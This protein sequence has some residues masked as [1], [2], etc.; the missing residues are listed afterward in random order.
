VWYSIG[1]ENEAILNLFDPET[2]EAIQLR[3]PLASTED[4]A[5]INAGMKSRKF[6][7]AITDR[8][9][10][11]K[12]R[13][14]ILSIDLIL[15]LWDF[16]EN[17]K[18]LEPL[19]IAMKLLVDLAPRETLKSAFRRAY[20]RANC[21]D[22]VLLRRDGKHH[23]V[24]VR[25]DPAKLFDLSYIQLFLF[26][27]GDFT[28][29]ANVACRKDSDGVKPIV[30]EPSALV[31]YRFATFASATGFDSL[32]IRRL[33]SRDPTS[34]QVLS[35][36]IQLESDDENMDEESLRSETQQI[37]SLRKARRDQQHRNNSLSEQEPDLT[38][39]F[40]DQTLEQRCGR[41]FHNAQKL[42]SKYMFLRWVF[43]TSQSRGRYITS[44]FVK[45]AILTAFLEDPSSLIHS[46]AEPVTEEDAYMIDAA[47]MEAERQLVSMENPGAESATA[48]IL[49]D[50][51]SQSD[52][53]MV[54][55]DQF[56]QSYKD[57]SSLPIA[58]VSSCYP[59]RV[60]L[61]ASRRGKRAIFS[62]P[63]AKLSFIPPQMIMPLD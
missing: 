20:T 40:M 9:D 10:R 30:E 43:S 45:R 26:C 24:P 3:A 57:M 46:S 31:I 56:S 5:F 29:M 12:I 7:P 54:L 17:T 23:L 53:D 1:S 34:L 28:H 35:C 25:C 19:V 49:A 62:R 18:Y 47:Q 39:D 55:A 63:K 52:E 60:L 16:C 13:L 11:E 21:Q 36:L 2:V 48:I 27:A 50:Q 6:F 22:G 33:K 15:S 37:L 41:A 32:K 8:E 61:T 42:D 4:A 51:F 59:L 38:T 14:N 58:T 44:F